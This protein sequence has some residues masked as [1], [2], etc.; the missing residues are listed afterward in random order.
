MFKIYKLK[1]KNVYEFLSL[2]G[3][4]YFFIWHTHV[5][6]CRQGTLQRLHNRLYVVKVTVVLE[7]SWLGFFHSMV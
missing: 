1:H 3:N 6:E 5:F 7:R 2:S 4:K